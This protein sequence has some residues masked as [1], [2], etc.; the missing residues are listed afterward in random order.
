MVESEAVDGVRAPE[1][2]ERRASGGEHTD[3]MWLTGA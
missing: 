2:R 3:M 1:E